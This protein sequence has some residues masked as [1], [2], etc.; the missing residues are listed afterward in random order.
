MLGL[1]VSRT[2]LMLGVSHQRRPYISLYWSLY[3]SAKTRFIPGYSAYTPST[4]PPPTPPSVPFYHYTILSMLSCAIAVSTTSP[5][6]L[7]Q[8]R[9]QTSGADKNKTSVGGIV[10]E[11]W[12]QGG[13]RAFTRG[14]SMRVAYSLPANA[15]SMTTYEMIKR[16]KGMT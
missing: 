5:I 13:P 4:T 16:W 2:L 15:L 10:K 11:L 12:R 3:E 14:M 1:R 9:W 7:V 6:E 8:S